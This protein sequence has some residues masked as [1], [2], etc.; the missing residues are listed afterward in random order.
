MRPRL[1]IWMARAIYGGGTLLVA[2]AAAYRYRLDYDVVHAP[3]QPFVATGN[4]VVRASQ[5]VAHYITPELAQALALSTQAMIAG[6]AAIVAGV[7][8][9][10]GAGA[11]R[12][13]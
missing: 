1:R 11:F 4:V 12:K 8:L 10:W 6:A 13:S 5:G 9:E 3:L 7:L 2:A